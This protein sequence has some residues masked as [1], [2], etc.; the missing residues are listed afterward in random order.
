VNP[1][2]TNYFQ[3]YL[4]PQV[5]ELLTNYGNAPVIW[6]DGEWI[7]DFT[8]EMGIELY[9][10]IIDIDSTTIINNRV[11]KGRQGMSGGN[12]EGDFR[13]DFFTPEQEIPDTGW[14]C[15]DWEACMTMNDTWGYKYFDTNW[16][17]TETLIHQLVEIASK[18][19]NFLLNVGP[20]AEGVIPEASI[21]RLKE[22]G[23]W[24]KVN[25]ESIYGTTTS[26]YE[27]PGW[28]RYTQKE[29]MLYAHIFEWPEDNKLV[30]TNKAA[31]KNAKL[32]AD[33]KE[34]TIKK[35]ETGTIISLPGK[36]NEI[37]TVIA[38]ELN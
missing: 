3:N 29:N 19:G 16:K 17:S 35:N 8:H 37:V 11:D 18:G 28:G 30:I 6:F 2:F 21:E 38:L 25:S 12:A 27:K 13:G 10:F 1:N 24:M 20:T 5:R 23:E 22:M 7:P 31:I 4:K 15:E 32:L 26:P 14:P 9:D 36:N 34:L 33:K